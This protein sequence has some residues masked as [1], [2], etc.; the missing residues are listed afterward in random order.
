M[1]GQSAQRIN[2]A[3]GARYERLALRYLRN[4]GL[5][6][7]AQNFRCR[8]GEIDL[9]MR[10]ARSLVFVEVRYRSASRFSSAAHSVDERK[11]A[12]I[13]RTAA[14]FLA[15]YPHYG[16]CPVRFDVV[17]FDGADNAQGRIQWIRDAFRV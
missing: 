4:D 8:L 10:D 14:M 17:A 2:R 16:D 7:L 11:Q 12:K 15:K 3:K 5:T 13:A 9:V 6:L 1:A